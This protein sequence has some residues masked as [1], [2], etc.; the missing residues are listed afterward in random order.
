MVRTGKITHTHTHTHT[1]IATIYLTLS[2]V[3]QLYL[4]NRGKKA[5]AGKIVAARSM[6]LPVYRTLST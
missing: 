3:L 5:R 2:V 6:I 1:H 4:A